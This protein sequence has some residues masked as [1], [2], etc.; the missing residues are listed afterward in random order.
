MIVILIYNIVDFKVIKI[1]DNY[2]PTI[3]YIFG[4]CLSLLCLLPIPVF[5]CMELY[6][7]TGFVEVR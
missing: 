5:M 2:F 7:Q 4:G 6:K 3:A 1:G